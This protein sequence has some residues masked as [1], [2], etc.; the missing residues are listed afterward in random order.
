MVLSIKGDNNHLTVYLQIVVNISVTNYCEFDISIPSNEQIAN[1]MRL[2]NI[3]IVE[4]EQLELEQ[5]EH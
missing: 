5:L 1:R 3:K 4:I 2:E